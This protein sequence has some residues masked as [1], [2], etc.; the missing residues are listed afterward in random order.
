M[1]RRTT[2]QTVSGLPRAAGRV[3]YAT[4]L[5]TRRVARTLLAASI[6]IVLFGAGAGRPAPKEG[7]PTSSVARSIRLDP[8]A[9]AAPV[10]PTGSAT[11]SRR[12]AGRAVVSH[13]E[14]DD[15]PAGACWLASVGGAPPSC[16]CS[17]GSVEDLLT[18]DFMH[19]L[20]TAWRDVGSLSTSELHG[21]LQEVDAACDRREATP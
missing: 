14:D 17:A 1:L 5:Y 11:L 7:V 9:G 8:A 10:L 6:G 15:Q 4:R 2:T 12:G 21:R 20:L 18:P 13:G 16:L 3:G 19:A